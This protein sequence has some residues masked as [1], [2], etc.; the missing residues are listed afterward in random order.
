MV[1]DPIL[2]T[3][4]GF[5]CL[6]TAAKHGDKSRDATQTCTGRTVMRDLKQ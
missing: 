1:S 4:D 5:M 6:T 3:C 2:I